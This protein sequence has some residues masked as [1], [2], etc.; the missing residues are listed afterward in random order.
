MCNVSGNRQ[1]LNP[2]DINI[3][4]VYG[5]RS[6]GL[7]HSGLDKLCGML[8]MPKPMTI[9]NFNNISSNLRDVAK[10]VA[11]KTMVDAIDELRTY[12]LEPIIDI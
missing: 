2:Y 7:D 4:A 9:K 5:M 12:R 6:V 3:R 11:E 8:N 10:V 1:G